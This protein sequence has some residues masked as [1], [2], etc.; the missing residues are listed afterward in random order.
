MAWKH[1]TIAQEQQ[2]VSLSGTHSQ[3][4]IAKL[5]DISMTTVHVVQR[6]YHITHRFG[7]HHAAQ[8]RYAI[9]EHAWGRIIEALY[10]EQHLSLKE[11]AERCGVH[12][13]TLTRRMHKLGIPIRTVGD[14]NR[15]KPRG[16]YAAW[17]TKLP[18]CDAD[19]G[20]GVRPPHTTC[21][22]CRRKQAI[23]SST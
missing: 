15:G 8:R 21:S 23:R 6:K 3:R 11:T 20:R 22:I 17:L 12:P 9:D 19:C 14:A 13:S 7:R 4:E 5:F 1:R 18:R 16:R 10:T 2:I